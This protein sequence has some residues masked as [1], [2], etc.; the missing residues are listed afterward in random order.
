MSALKIAQ[1]DL[2]EIPDL[3]AES[4]AEDSVRVIRE[5][6]VEW[7]RAQLI[8]NRH[9]GFHDPRAVWLLPIWDE[10]CAELGVE[11]R[12]MLCVR[13]PAQ[14]AQSVEALGLE[15]MAENPLV[16]QLIK[17]TFDLGLWEN[18]DQPAATAG[19]F[20]QDLYDRIVG[21]APAGCLDQSVRSVAGDIIAFAAFV[22]PMLSTFGGGRVRS[23]SGE[24]GVRPRAKRGCA[25]RA[26]SYA[27]RCGQRVRTDADARSRKYAASNQDDG[28]GWPPVH[29]FDDA[30]NSFRM[31]GVPYV[32]FL[33]ALHTHLTPRTY[34]E[35]GT[36]TGT[37]LALAGCDAIAVDPQFQ[38]AVTATGNRRRTFFFQMPSDTF[39]ATENVRQLL[40]RPVDMV[41]LDGM[42]RFEFLLRDLI[43]AEAACHPRSLILLHD[44]VPLNPRMALRQ[45]LPGE[46]FE[47]DTAG[48]WTGDVWKL[49]P[50]LKKY[51]PD[52]RLHVLDC[53]PTGL[54][55]IN[56]VD[57]A[58]HVLADCS[59]DIVDEHAATV[60]DE[61]RLRS[62]WEELEMTDSGPLCEE[63]DRLTELFSLY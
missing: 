5:E 62:L 53:P 9:F 1:C 44:C 6:M 18:M 7:L 48:M 39:F 55:A 35:V 41:F 12:Y 58:S 61:N 27:A 54:V 47:K 22:Q 49:L 45:W 17:Q 42:H 36:E 59:Y 56:S 16:A 46:S 29:D 60:M 3:P 20:A 23:A 14:V 2:D 8:R 28:E 33:T 11:V 25:L 30:T 10:I 4:W 57:P 38:L 50:I 34:L 21:C 51:R 19:R 31:L 40:G 63:P 43:G 13:E 15:R 32:D 24:G 52:L 26:N 37:S